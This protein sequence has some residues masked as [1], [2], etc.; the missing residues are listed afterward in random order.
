MSQAESST[1]VARVE[2]IT[3]QSL[4]PSVVA[5]PSRQRSSP[6][7]YGI[8]IIAVAFLFFGGVYVGQDF[9]VERHYNAGLYIEPGHLNFG[10]VW[11]VKDFKWRIPI[12]NISDRPVGIAEFTAS[13]Q[14]DLIEP[15]SLTIPPH[16]TAEVVATIDLTKGHDIEPNESTRK[17]EIAIHPIVAVATSSPPGFV[18]RGTAKDLFTASPRAIELGEILSR[19]PGKTTTI[20]LTAATSLSSLIVLP[21]SDMAI[22]IKPFEVSPSPPLPLSSS[23]PLEKPRQPTTGTNAAPRSE[24]TT[25][26][27]LALTPSNQIPLGRI[28]RQ[29]L[30][31][32]TDAQ[33]RAMPLFPIKLT[34]AIVFDVAVE[35]PE[36]YAGMVEMDGTYETILTLRSRTGTRFALIPLD[37]QSGITLTPVSQSP[38]LPSDPFLAEDGV[39]QAAFCLRLTPQSRGDQRSTA[40]FQAINLSTGE[41]ADLDIPIIYNG[42]Q[43]R[44][45]RPEDVFA[46]RFP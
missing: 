7:L 4:P 40:R 15:P 37:Q 10:E 27:L 1:E 34:G 6:T 31:Q 24:H 28:D 32:S 33:G 35:P 20:R 8:A 43:P 41:Q 17:F 45:V 25:E 3:A 26:Y 14:C 38:P 30:L 21:Q 22:E 12:Q 11:A 46:Q 18:L 39:L 19:T 44:P 42:V 13:C 29:V 16:S 5:A 9:L 2:P 23:A 36:I